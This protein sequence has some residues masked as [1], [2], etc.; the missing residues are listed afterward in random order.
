V[1]VA[2]KGL[3]RKT[4]KQRKLNQIFWVF[5]RRSHCR[6]EWKSKKLGI[7]AEAES[8]EHSRSAAHELR[9]GEKYRSVVLQ[10]FF[11]TRNQACLRN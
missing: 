1:G 10:F 6:P 3:G 8:D 4:A 9:G 11:K 7:Y 2:G 5:G